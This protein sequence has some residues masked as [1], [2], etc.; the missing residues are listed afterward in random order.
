MLFLPMLADAVTFLG[1]ASFLT[2]LKS[3]DMLKPDIAKPYQAVCSKSQAITSYLFGDELPK[4]IKEIG[5]VNTITRRLAS[6]SL[7]SSSRYGGKPY[8]S[9]ALYPGSNKKTFLGYQGRRNYF[10]DR[11]Q[12]STRVIPAATKFLN[13]NKV[14]IRYKLVILKTVLKA[15]EKSLAI[16]GSLKLSLDP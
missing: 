9:S 2:S 14:E 3:K 13:K 15:G 10:R 6:R 16:L 12:Y 4:H 5:E 11:N 1:H 8:K 7:S